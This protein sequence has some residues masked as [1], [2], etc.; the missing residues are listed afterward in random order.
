[1]CWGSSKACERTRPLLRPSST[2]RLAA[3]PEGTR[4]LQRCAPLASPR[5]SRSARIP[6]LQLATKHAI[7]LC[8]RPMFSRD[9]D[10]PRLRAGLWWCVC[11]ESKPRR[12]RVVVLL[13]SL[14]RLSQRPTPS[15]LTY[16]HVRFCLGWVG[17]VVGLGGR[18]AAGSGQAPQWKE[19]EDGFQVSIAHTMRIAT[20][21]GL[22]GGG[23][24]R[25]LG[26]LAR[27]D[28]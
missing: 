26:L 2:A 11:A 15:A 21:H 19:L 7:A 20:K 5:P 22:E 4:T 27:P 8:L 12:P 3:P 17:R 16:L 1:M 25:C 28:S 10:T 18:P 24:A 9:G 14:P 13:L 23:G 6:T